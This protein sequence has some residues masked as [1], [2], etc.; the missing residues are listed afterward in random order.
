MNNTQ[1]QQTLDMLKKAKN[2]GIS[3][4]EIEDDTGLP[5]DWMRNLERFESGRYTAER[6]EALHQH[7]RH[8]LRADCK[9]KRG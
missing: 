3:F 4:E 9:K 8:I 7:L 1:Y 2:M 6:V 5:S